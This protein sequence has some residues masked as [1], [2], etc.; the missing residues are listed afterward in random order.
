MR[1]KL[2]VPFMIA[3]I[4]V[5][6]SCFAQTEK[7]VQEQD[8]ADS[9]LQ[10][11]TIKH[12]GFLKDDELI[13]QYRKDDHE[14]TKVI[15]E[16]KVVPSEEFYQYEGMLHNYLQFRSLDDIVPRVSRLKREIRRQSARLVPARIRDLVRLQLRVDSLRTGV[17]FP[18]ER[19]AQKLRESI[20]QTQIDMSEIKTRL[21]L[22]QTELRKKIRELIDELHDQGIIPGKEDITIKTK[23]GKCWV[24]GRRLSDEETEKL[25]EIWNK[26]MEMPF[27]KSDRI[28]NL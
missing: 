18:K 8:K 1:I 10:Q 16:G 23:K 5:S 28:I 17:V 2:I 9:T 25:E 27:E 4:L 12:S 15:D 7:K 13:I 22:R 19:I 14:I 11:I 26:H 20:V 3:T 21:K 6:L 24:N